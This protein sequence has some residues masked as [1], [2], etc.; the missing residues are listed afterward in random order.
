M[1]DATHHT[2]WSICM[3]YWL[4]LYIF[5][6]SST[7]DSH[8][9]S[10]AMVPT[11]HGSNVML[12]IGNASSIIVIGPFVCIIHSYQWHVV[13]VFVFIYHHR[14]LFHCTLIVMIVTS[15]MF[16]QST[17]YLYGVITIN[18]CGYDAFI[19]YA[20]AAP[21]RIAL[22]SNPINSIPHTASNQSSM[23]HRLSSSLHYNVMIVSFHI[24][25]LLL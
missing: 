23:V 3:Y 12:W 11:R 16:H 22:A 24:S 13:V 1:K 14:Q 20:Y 8:H 5:H 2:S 4:S 19:S 18:P 10:I 25:M 21:L 15:R 17:V 6:Q 7:I 9:S